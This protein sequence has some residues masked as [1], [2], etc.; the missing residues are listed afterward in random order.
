MIKNKD[1]KVNLG[2]GKNKE[3]CQ[4]YRGLLGVQ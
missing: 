2:K 4:T 1:S 3:K